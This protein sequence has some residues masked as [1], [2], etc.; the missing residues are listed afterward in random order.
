MKVLPYGDSALLLD[1]DDAA[2]VLPL[3]AACADVHGV[4]EVVPAARTVLLVLD[5]PDVA[6]SVTSVVAAL[7][8]RPPG[9]DASSGADDVVLDVIYDGAD[10]AS[11]ASELGLDVDGLVR[12]HSAAAYVVAFCGFVPGFA[13]LSG[14][15]ADLHVARLASPRTRVPSGSVGIAGEF[16]GVYP[17]E[18]PGG[19]AV[20]GLDRRRP[21]GRIADSTGAAL[22]RHHCSLQSDMNSSPI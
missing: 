18:S 1:L 5:G 8:P 21:V 16:T 22:P 2:L 19:V 17:R 7:D 13:Y 20:A 14:L 9:L 3:A 6:R 11:T 15:P 4:R 12:A 10:L